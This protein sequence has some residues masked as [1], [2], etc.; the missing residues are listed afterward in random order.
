MSATESGRPRATP[1]PA[2]PSAA[3]AL[4]A[5][6]PPVPPPLLEGVAELR[7]RVGHGPGTEE[8]LESLARRAA[9]KAGRPRLIDLPCRS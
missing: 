8:Y 3:A 9:E 7:K 6:S 2:A 5:P 4:P 1:L